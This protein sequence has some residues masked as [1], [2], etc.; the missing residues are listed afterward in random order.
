MAM[1]AAVLLPVVIFIVVISIAMVKRGEICHAWAKSMQRRPPRL[2]RKAAV[3]IPRRAFFSWM[4]VAWTAFTASMVATASATGRFMFPNVLFEPPATFKAGIPD[5]IQVGQ[6]DERFKQKLGVWL[7]KDIDIQTGAHGIYALST[8]CTHLGCTPDWLPAAQKFKCPCHGSGYYKNGINF[9]GPTPRPL[10]RFAISLARGRPDPGGQEYE[11]PVRKGPVGGSAVFLKSLIIKLAMAK[12]IQTIKD[13]FQSVSPAKIGQSIQETQ[14]YRSVF[15]VGVPD[16]D[17]KRMLVMLGSVFLHLHP[18]KVRKSGIRMRYTWCMGGITFFLFLVLTFT[19]LLLMF[20]Y[21]PTLDYAYVG[22][23]RP[24]RAGAA[25]HHARNSPVGRARDGDR[26]VAPH[27]PRLHDRFLQAATRVQLERRRHS[28]RAD[29]APELHRISSAVGSA[30]HV[31]HHRRQQHGP[32]NAV[33]RTRRSGRR[34]CS[35]LEI[36]A[37]V[38]NASDARFALLG[39]RFVGEGALLR[40]YVLHCV[41]LPLVAGFLMAIHFWRIRRDGG[42]SGPL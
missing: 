32:R 36:S 11:V 31:G 33:R 26:R 28:A 25:G 4:G 5:E 17:R 24:P 42:I 41:G 10:E 13:L 9:E 19:G 6:V 38:N 16:T 20:Y 8:V 2:R 21:R 7:V 3:V 29:A 15:R 39:G 23:H 37:L 40:F 18:V 12:I 30:G 27:V 35:R 14:L 22:H 1:A 34:A